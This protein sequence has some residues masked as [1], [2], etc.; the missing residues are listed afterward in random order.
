MAKV[1]APLLS[2]GARGTFAKTATYGSWKGI[3]Y[4][5]QRVTPANPRSS[6]QTKTRSSFTFASAAWRTMDPDLKAPWNDS[7]NGRPVTGRNLWIG[8]ATKNLRGQTDLT[9]MVTSPGTRSAPGLES[10]SASAGTA[11]GEIDT[12][13]TTP[14]V[15]PGWTLDAVRIVQKSDQDP[16][17]EYDD[18]LS[19]TDDTTVGNSTTLSGLTAGA[20][21]YV[22]AF[23][24]FTRTDGSKAYG[25]SSQA[26]QAA[27]T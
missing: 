7:A 23:P 15:P 4:A 19:H 11:S 9:G 27:Q 5:R 17:T 25:P 24:V 8:S 22:S 26:I 1:D 3:K 14:A 21:Y 16:S 10:F 2:I 20:D 18:D 12:S 13:Y 6:E